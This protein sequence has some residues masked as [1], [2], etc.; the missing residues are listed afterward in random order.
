[1]ADIQTAKTPQPIWPWI[2]G[3]LALL[4]IVWIWAAPSENQV[5]GESEPTTD[6]SSSEPVETTELP[7]EPVR[8]YQQFSGVIAGGGDIPEM[9][10]DHAYTAD[11][12]R[13]LAAALESLAA[14]N[15][16]ADTRAKLEQFRRD[17]DRLQE[18]PKSTG[19]AKIAREVFI[20]AVDVMAS[21]EAGPPATDLRALAESIDPNQPLLGQRDKVRSFFRESAQV[22]RDAEKAG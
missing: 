5:T 16:D 6:G 14:E 18:D 1:M 11:G 12:I 4:L 8:V 21:I 17:A 2:V 22:I 9:G 15:A 10:V 13:K 19:H 20:S 3:V 7:S